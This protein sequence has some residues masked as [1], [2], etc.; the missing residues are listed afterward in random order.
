MPIEFSKTSHIVQTLPTGDPHTIHAYHFAGEPGP[1]IYI[2]ANLH[3]PEIIGTPLIGKLIEYLHTLD[4]IKGSITL[5]PCAN[6]LAVNDSNLALDGRWNKKSGQ[7]WNRIHDF[8]QQWHSREDK[9]NYLTNFLKTQGISI[10]KKLSATLHLIAGQPDYIIDLHAAGL[11]SC[12]YRF[13]MPQCIN[14]FDLLGNELAL[15]NDSSD[16]IFG[17]F[18]GSFVRPFRDTPELISKACTW[19]LAGDQQVDRSI[20]EARWVAMKRWIDYVL[21]DVPTKNPNTTIVRSVT[22]FDVINSQHHGYYIWEVQV[23]DIVPAGKPYI[24]YYE[25]VTNEFKSFSESRDFMLVSKYTIGAL[26][27]GE[28]IGERV[29]L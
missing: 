13:V 8:G 10:E 19:E 18:K 4:T 29:W 23:G 27:E 20:L 5:V 22:E 16:F 12:D 24:T 1:S 11:Y 15:I 26:G 17:D 25:P 6:P 14:D 2:Q 7:N 28:Q 3:G 9:K 21:L